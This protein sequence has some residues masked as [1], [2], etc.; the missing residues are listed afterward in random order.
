LKVE[1]WS[2]DLELIMAD[3]VRQFYDELAGEYDLMFADWKQ[4]VLRQSEVLDAFIRRHE[5]ESARSVLDCACGIGTQAIALAMR[6]YHV[7]ATDFSASSVER[8]KK[9]SESFGVTM[10]FGVADWLALDATVEADFDIV[11]CLDNAL[12]HLLDD[13]DLRQ[14]A[15]QMRARLRPDG[16][17]IASIRDYDSVVKETTAGDGPVIQGLP[18]VAGQPGADRPR[19]TLPRVFE[20]G[21]RRRIA[22][23]VWD[24]AADGRSY[25]INQFFLRETEGGWGASHYLSRFRALLRDE[26]SDILR[27]AEFSDI[28]W[29]TPAESGFYQPIVTARNRSRQP[30]VGRQD[31]DHLSDH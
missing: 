9:E 11:I 24:W 3:S 10:T 16:L 19:A 25:A 29:H 12:S 22:F 7:H 18:G 13:A 8:A 31:G 5:G 6:G 27:A 28:R 14:A 20:D 30:E 2:F 1:H 15:R 17:L 4:E 26:L 23:Q 21:D